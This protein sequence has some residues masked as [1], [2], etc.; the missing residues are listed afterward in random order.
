MYFLL[1]KHKVSWFRSFSSSSKCIQCMF[2]YCC[3]KTRQTLRGRTACFAVWVRAEVN[4][5]LLAIDVFWRRVI[6]NLRDDFSITHAG[7]HLKRKRKCSGGLKR[8]RTL[9]NG[10]RQLKWVPRH[11]KR[12][13]KMSKH[14]DVCVAQLPVV[15]SAVPADE[16]CVTR[17]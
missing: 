8:S 1:F 11:Y 5:S 12:D 3:W 9:K 16:T 14:C 7:L 15:V 6:L 10:V 2:R 17:A 4:T 13:Q